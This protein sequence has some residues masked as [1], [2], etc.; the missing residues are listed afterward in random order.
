MKS[1]VE[2]VLLASVFG[3]F[4]GSLCIAYNLGKLAGLRRVEEI[5]EMTADE[6]EEELYG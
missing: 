4:M 3:A 1:L 2:T 6:I 5:H